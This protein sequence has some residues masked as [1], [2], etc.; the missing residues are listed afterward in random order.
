MLFIGAI[1][2]PVVVGAL[3]SSGFGVTK[4]SASMAELTAVSA[5]LALLRTRVE[6]NMPVLTVATDCK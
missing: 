6:A 5:V 2:A 4:P 1:F 3:S